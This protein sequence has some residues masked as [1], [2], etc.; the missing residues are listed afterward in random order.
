MLKNLYKFLFT[1]IFTVADFTEANVYDDGYNRKKNR[2]R[3]RKQQNHSDKRKSKMKVASAKSSVA[4]DLIKEE[5]ELAKETFLNTPSLTLPD[6]VTNSPIKSTTNGGHSAKKKIKT[7][8]PKKR[9]EKQIV[10]EEELLVSKDENFIELVPCLNIPDFKLAESP[11]KDPLSTIDDSLTHS[12]DIHSGLDHSSSSTKDKSK[13]KEKTPRKRQTKKEPDGKSSKPSKKNKSKTSVPVLDVSD[14]NILRQLVNGDPI[15]KSHHKDLSFD[16]NQTYSVGNVQKN[17]TQSSNILQSP[18]LEQSS[19]SKNNGRSKTSKSK[20]FLSLK[21]SILKPP[22]LQIQSDHKGENKTQNTKTEPA[23]SSEMNVALNSTWPITSND[24]SKVKS[25]STLF[26]TDANVNLDSS[27]FI[28]NSILLQ[29]I[30]HPF[31]TRH[32][33]ADQRIKFGQNKVFNSHVGGNHWQIGNRTYFFNGNNENNKDTVTNSEISNSISSVSNVKQTVL[34]AALPKSVDDDQQKSTASPSLSMKIE[35]QIAA[36]TFDISSQAEN[37][38][39]SQ[40]RQSPK[41]T[42]PSNT[43]VST[44]DRSNLPVQ[45]SP[46]HCSP[47]SLSKETTLNQLNVGS[48]FDILPLHLSREGVSITLIPKNNNASTVGSPRKQATPR[49]LKVNSLEDSTGEP[50]DSEISIIKKS[51]TTEEDV[52][53]RSF[54]QPKIEYKSNSNG[55]SP[56]ETQEECTDEY[57]DESTFVYSIPEHIK[58][59]LFPSKPD[60][61]VLQTF[62]HYWSSHVPHCSICA[63]LSL[64][65]HKGCKPMSLDWKKCKPT[66]LPETSPIWVRQNTVVLASQ[67]IMWMLKL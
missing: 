52:N 2:K 59:M 29:Q 51:P 10:P 27:T 48:Q 57:E 58:P 39:N 46:N 60:L 62:N 43:I 5:S 49:K 8:L 12:H 30:P 54:M 14:V 38:L 1:F 9:K 7:K 50:H 18:A 66:V 44:P 26:N 32:S 19:S 33:L 22:V 67:M 34:A 16:A 11:L 40:L 36:N 20:G 13:F 56:I 45:I 31:Q 41:E 65:N 24:Q 3:K 28:Q 6:F 53:L 47:N 15:E 4:S 42:K 23:L 17:E 55:G 35:P 61:N 37:N 25:V 21:K 64:R 63:A